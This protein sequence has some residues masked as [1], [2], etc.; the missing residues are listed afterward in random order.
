[1]QRWLRDRTSYDIAFR[2]LET[3]LQRARSVE[4][5][6]RL[7]ISMSRDGGR[8]SIGE[9]ERDGGV[10]SEN[11]GFTAFVKWLTRNIVEQG[12]DRESSN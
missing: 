12:R 7:R 11:I 5:V 4:S 8:S 1:M 6:S 3:S 2:V 9:R 10:T